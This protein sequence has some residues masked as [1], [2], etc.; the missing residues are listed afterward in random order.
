MYRK[1]TELPTREGWYWYRERE[2]RPWVMVQVERV[3]TGLHVYGGTPSY[4]LERSHGE[5]VS[6]PVPGG[7][8]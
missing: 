7:D 8:L 2:G 1:T 3:E 6:V 5:W 4:I